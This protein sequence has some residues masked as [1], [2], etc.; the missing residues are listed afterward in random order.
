[1]PGK[2]CTG[3]PTNSKPRLT[4]SKAFCEGMA[5]RASGTGIDKP[6]TDN[7]HEAGSEDSTAWNAGWTVANDNIGST[8]SRADLGCCAAVPAVPP[9]PE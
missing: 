1:M 2:L 5:Y 8:I 9:I 6:I 3:A 4:S 7:P